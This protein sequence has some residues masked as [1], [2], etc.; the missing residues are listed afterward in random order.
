MICSA[1]N[2][3]IYLYHHFHV[4]F[5][6][7]FAPFVKRVYERILKYILYERDID[8]AFEYAERE[9]TDLLHGRYPIEDLVVSRS[10]SRKPDTYA[11]QVSRI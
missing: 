11:N 7:D 9:M 10:I 1:Y 4:L 3:C 5:L 6:S 8:S 2:V